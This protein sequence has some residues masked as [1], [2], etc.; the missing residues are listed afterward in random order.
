MATL[1]SQTAAPTVKNAKRRQKYDKN[2]AMTLKGGN[3]R[4]L[5]LPYALKAGH[6]VHMDLPPMTTSARE[7]LPTEFNNTSLL[8]EII[9]QFY[10]DVANF[11]NF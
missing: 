1:I 3:G 2:G 5:S 6:D 8:L 9:L 7:Q 10:R 4:K 11:S